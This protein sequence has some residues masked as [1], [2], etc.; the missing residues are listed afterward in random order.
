MAGRGHG[1][2]EGGDRRRRHQRQRRLRLEADQAGRHHRDAGPVLRHDVHD[3][4]YGYIQKFAERLLLPVTSDADSYGQ[5]LSDFFPNSPR[6]RS[7]AP[8]ASSGPCLCTTFPTLWGWNKAL[9]TKIGEDPENPPDN[10][11]DLFKLAPKFKAAGII[12][13]VQPWLATQANLF[14]LNYFVNIWNSTGMPFLSPDR[15]QIGFD[16]DD[17][18]A[19]LRAHR[20]GVQERVLGLQVHEPHQRARCLQDLRRRQRGHDHREREPDPDRGHGAVRPE[21]RL[22]ACIRAGRR[23][24][25]ARRA[26]PTASASASSRPS[27]TPAGAG[28]ATTSAPRSRRPRR[29]PSRTARARSCTSPSPGRRWSPIPDVIKAQPLQ[30]LYA[31]QNKFQTDRWSSPYDLAPVFNE[32]IAKMIT[33]TTTQRRAMGRGRQ[34]LTGHHH[35]V[36]EQLTVPSEGPEGRFHARNR[37][38]PC[39]QAQLWSPAARGHDGDGPQLVRLIGVRRPGAKRDRGVATVGADVRAPCLWKPREATALW[40]RSRPRA[41]ICQT[42]RRSSSLNGP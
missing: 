42:Y 34:G 4:A 25:A 17:G 14:A 9:F 37:P 16:N 27:R 15:T 38:S 30:P 13:S 31:E 22:R 23:A 29:R 32:V 41:L 19:D 8:T 18:Q 5:D 2:L 35:Q 40:D 10:Y 36:P 6:Q 1:G 11:P 7:P 20:G 12:P 21:P 3:A 39:S 26:G 33:A 28:R 24:R